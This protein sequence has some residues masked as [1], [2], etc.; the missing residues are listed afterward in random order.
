LPP[1]SRCVA[2]FAAHDIGWA[3]FCTK[4]SRGGIPWQEFG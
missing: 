2:H 1:G 3:S 4:L